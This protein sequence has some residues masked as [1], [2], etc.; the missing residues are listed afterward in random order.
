MGLRRKRRGICG[1]TSVF[2]GAKDGVF[3]AVCEVYAII[4]RARDAGD[5]G[6]DCGVWGVG[7]DAAEFEFAGECGVESAERGGVDSDVGDD[8]DD[9]DG[10]DFAADAA[11]AA[12][13]GEETAEDY[14]G[15]SMGVDAGDC[16][17]VS[18]C[19]GV[20]CADAVDGGEVYGKV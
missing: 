13:D 10:G 20:L 15:D 14:D 7:A 4:R 6:A 2:E 18:E 12:E 5:Y 3:A 19:G 11:A 8:W 9:C 1:G 17:C 16:D